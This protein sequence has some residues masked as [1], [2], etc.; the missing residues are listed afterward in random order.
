ME[1]DFSEKGIISST[2]LKVES[3][4]TQISVFYSKRSIFQAH[5]IEGKR[6][7]KQRRWRPLSS[8]N[9]YHYLSG[10]CLIWLIDLLIGYGCQ[11]EV[12]MRGRREK[13]R[14]AGVEDLC[15]YAWTLWISWRIIQ[16]TIS[17]AEFREGDFAG[18]ALTRGEAKTSG[19]NI[20]GREDTIECSV[21]ELV[22]NYWDKE[23]GKVATYMYEE[24]K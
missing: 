10:S 6:S 12:W 23:I 2:D 11:G 5:E 21:F 13:V 15:G 19:L 16:I 17:P 22:L 7:S 3:R 20:N 14:M 24:L 4:S 1:S 18:R 9:G 8:P